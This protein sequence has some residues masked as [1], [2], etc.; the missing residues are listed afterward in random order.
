MGRIETTLHASYQADCWGKLE[1]VREIISNAI[2]GEVRFNH[3]GIG[4]MVIEYNQFTSTLTVR[5]EGVDVPAKALLMGTSESR[6]DDRAIGQFGEGLPMGL[7]AL[8][9]AGCEVEIDNGVER[10]T[11]SIDYSAQFGSEPVLV[12]KTRKLRQPRE[13]F[14]VRIG[15]IPKDFYDAEVRGM[16][17][18]MD[19][20]FDPSKAVLRRGGLLSEEQSKLTYLGSRLCFDQE[21]VLLQ[22][23]MCGKIYNKGVFVMRRDDL[24]FGYN[25]T[26]ALNRDR[27]HM[28]EWDLRSK[29]DQLL[30][31]TK[32]NSLEFGTLLVDMLL[33][34]D[35]D[36]LELQEA[37]TYLRHDADFVEQV[38]KKF[39]ERHT[40]AG[41]PSGNEDEDQRIRALGRVPVRTSP[42]LLSV[43]TQKLGSLSLLEG[44]RGQKAVDV[45]LESLT[46]PER[47]NFLLVQALLYSAQPQTQ[48]VKFVPAVFNSAAVH[49]K[50]EGQQ[51]RI[52]R[53]DLLD[54]DVLLLSAVR[55]SAVALNN[56]FGATEQILAAV[57]A[58]VL[59]GD[60]AVS[61][62][63]L[64]QR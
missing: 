44:E 22:R 39:V 58:R 17:L 61:L 8:A 15:S 63:L 54:L 4:K 18:Q 2:D 7:L 52:A 10:W 20:A 30:S 49:F 21:M 33:A 59:T 23:H 16:F 3:L 35:Q 64:A 25:L 41:F 47:H 27:K 6:S 50:T 57:L 14:E 12:V 46:E 9:R 51:V 32:G 19:R 26:G 37:Y 13:H 36:K 62:S 56:T 1:G 28:D 48:V 40:E 55:G 45:A 42:L 53:A 29:L 43:L 31:S 11:P 5:N 38:T 60:A 34:N 24:L